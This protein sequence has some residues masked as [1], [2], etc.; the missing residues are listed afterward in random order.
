MGPRTLVIGFGGIGGVVSGHLAELGVEVVALSRNRAMAAAVRQ[1]GLT[2]CGVTPERNVPVTVVTE[3]PEG[4]FELIILATQPT[5]VEAAATIAA[6]RLSEG[7][8]IL[9][10]QNGLCEERVARILG[11]RSRVLGCVVAW[12]GAVVEPGVVEQTSAG[13]MTIGALDGRDDRDA[14]ELEALLAPIGPVK[15]TRN[16]LGARW[17]KLIINCVVSSL[18]TL[19]GSR[20]GPVVRTRVARRLGLEIMTEGVKVARA[21]GVELEMVAGTLDLERIALTPKDRAGGGLSLMGKHSLLLAVGMRYRRLYSSLLRAIEAG[22]PPAIDFLNGEIVRWAERL[23]LEAPVNQ[24]VCDRV[25]AFAAGELS[26]GPETIET[27]ADEI[28]GL[29]QAS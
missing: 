23:N 4:P 19:N 11:D 22:K 5:D 7:G 9:V 20:L 17:S 6:S 13:G 16:L 29:V 12:G 28:R 25:H 18:G 15:V 14:F 21:A 2:L 24:A 27:L 26:P 3:A 10:L 8:R 1:N